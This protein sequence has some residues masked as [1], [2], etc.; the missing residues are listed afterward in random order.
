M[1]NLIGKHKCFF[2]LLFLLITS[3]CFYENNLDG[4][5]SFMSILILIEVVLILF[6]IVLNSIIC[7]VNIKKFYLY[8]YSLLIIFSS[9]YSTS[10]ISNI[11]L[12]NNNQNWFGG[13]FD[14]FIEFSSF[15][16]Q[17]LN[18]SFFAI[19]VILFLGF[20]TSIFIFIIKL[21]NSYES[22]NVKYIKKV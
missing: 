14:R 4:L 12:E 6:Y 21:G 9:V 20:Y 8:F 15:G 11:V 18:Y 22:E 7:L 2:L 1:F 10:Y 5:P 17:E 16:N 13:M 3:I 19:T